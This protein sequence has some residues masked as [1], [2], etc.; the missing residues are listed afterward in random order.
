MC[1]LCHRSEVFATR[2]RELKQRGRSGGDAA[3]LFRQEAWQ[4]ER[5]AKQTDDPQEKEIIMEFVA[6]LREWADEA[7][8]DALAGSEPVP[9]MSRSGDER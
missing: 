9:Q 6:E 5:K 1:P 8:S 4:A 3:A 7:D 2:R